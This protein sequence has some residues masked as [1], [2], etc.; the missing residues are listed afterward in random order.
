MYFD[1][2]HFDHQCILIISPT[3]SDPLSNPFPD[4]Y[5]LKNTHK[6]QFVLILYSWVWGHPLKYG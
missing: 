2:S 5:F 6:V 3:L 1:H 4:L